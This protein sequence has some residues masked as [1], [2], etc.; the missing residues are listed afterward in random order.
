MISVLVQLQINTCHCLDRV[1]FVFIKDP[2]IFEKKRCKIP[3][4][5]FKWP[6]GFRAS[7]RAFIAIGLKN[8]FLNFVSPG[9]TASFPKCVSSMSGAWPLNEGGSRWAKLQFQGFSKRTFFIQSCWAGLTLYI[10]NAMSQR[11][12]CFTLWSSALRQFIERQSIE[13]QYIESRD[14]FLCR[15][16]GHSEAKSHPG[17]TAKVPPFQS[18]KLLTKISNDRK[19][20]FVLI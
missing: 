12:H 19:S 1:L 2:G 5:H 6:C 17:S 20:C 15:K 16:Q 11:V 9:A 18:L 8:A 14:L 4:Q 13:L 7:V 3:K 10:Q